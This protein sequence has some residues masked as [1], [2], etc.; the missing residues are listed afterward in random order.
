VNR[1]RRSTVTRD[2]LMLAVHKSARKYLADFMGFPRD[3]HYS[4]QEANWNLR[5]LYQ[6]G[7]RLLGQRSRFEVKTRPARGAT[8]VLRRTRQERAI[9][10]RKMRDKPTPGELEA[11]MRK[12]H[13]RAGATP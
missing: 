4:E 12:V 8:G 11:Y 6:F 7:L 5:H 10:L 1:T 13:E 2:E 9:K 3:T